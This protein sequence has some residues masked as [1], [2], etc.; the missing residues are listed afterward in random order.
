MS[1]VESIKELYREFCYQWG[2]KFNSKAAANNLQT[3][4]NLEAVDHLVDS[5]IRFYLELSTLVGRGTKRGIPDEHKI[6]ACIVKSILVRGGLFWHEEGPSP[7]DA[8]LRA[9]MARDLFFVTMGV[10]IGRIPDENPIKESIYHVF[11]NMVQK[12]ADICIF[13]LALKAYMLELPL[14]IWK[15][16]LESGQAVDDQV[17]LEMN[18]LFPEAKP[19]VDAFLRNSQGV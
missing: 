11:R 5:A 12:D 4:F 7:R 17:L 8:S 13:S 2:E 1:D 9:Q 16:I 14:R 6:T 10:A 18:Q 3:F 15:K 19:L